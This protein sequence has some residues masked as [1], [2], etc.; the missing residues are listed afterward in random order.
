FAG[1]YRAR[2]RY[3][4]YDGKTR[5]VEA[6]GRTKG[7]AERRL[8]ES[9]VDRSYSVTEAEI[10]PD[11][12]VRVLAEAWWSDF[13]SREPATGTLRLYRG[14]LDGVILPALGELRVRELSVG[15]LHRHM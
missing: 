9:L 13:Q 7:E 1:S 2:G 5:Q 15:T 4:D 11:T 10:S 12:K 14:R 8:R 3:R 6:S